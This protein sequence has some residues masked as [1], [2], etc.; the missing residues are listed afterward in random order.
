MSQCKCVLGFP[1]RCLLLLQG[2]VD[3]AALLPFQKMLQLALEPLL[4]GPS[5]VTGQKGPA[6]RQPNAKML[7]HIW[8]GAGMTQGHLAGNVRAGAELLSGAELHEGLQPGSMVHS[9]SRKHC[10]CWGVMSAVGSG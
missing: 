4:I 8:F 10:T 6:A 9:V 5:E 7:N 2:D 1:G 3:L